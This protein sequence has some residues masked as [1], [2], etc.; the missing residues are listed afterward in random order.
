MKLVNVYIEYSVHNNVAYVYFI[1]SNMLYGFHVSGFHAI[2]NP[3][4]K[5]L[6][7]NEES[8]INQ[9][10]TAKFTT[11][12]QV[13]NV[14]LQHLRFLLWDCLQ[15]AVQFSLPH[16]AIHISNQRS[17][18]RFQTTQRPASSTRYDIHLPRCCFPRCLI[19]H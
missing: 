5:N 7:R 4:L 3:P 6:K 15:N 8:I 18:R 9:L 17:L 12:S 13:K 16:L 11:P 10:L 14:I 2:K 19:R 1:L